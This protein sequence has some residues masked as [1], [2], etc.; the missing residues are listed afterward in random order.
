MTDFVSFKKQFKGDLV[1]PSDPG[2][3]EAIDRWAHNAARRAKVVA[4]VKDPQDVSLAIKYAKANALPIAIRGGGHSAAGT[5]SSEDGLVID[6]S[7]YINGVTVDAEKRLAYIGG[8]AVWKTVDHAA[9]QH[10]LATVGGTVNH[11]GVGGLILGGGYGWLSAQHGLAIDN[12]VQATIVPADGSVLTANSS[13]NSDLFWAIRGG[14]C[15]FGVVT[16]FVLKLFPQRRS[17]FAGQIVFTP[18]KLEQVGAALDKWW[19][20]AGSSGKAS[21]MSVMTR[22]PDG[23][24]CI[25]VSLFYNG[26]EAEGR[27]HYKILYDI[28]A[29]L[30]KEV[31]YEEVNGMQNAL[32]APGLNYYMKGALLSDTPSKDLRREVFD[33]V[34]SLS[35]EDLNV[36]II[37]ELLPHDK[38]NSVPAD[39]TPYRRNLHGNTLI[40]IQWKEHTPEKGKAARAAAHELAG[41]MP[42][43]EGY[44]N[45]AGTDDAASS[46]TGVAP[47]EK[48]QELFGQH[49]PRLQAI[50]KKYDP[51]M[52]FHKW[53]LIV[54]A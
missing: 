37:L 51:E 48:S 30:A 42:K 45:Y 28:V 24:P 14:G 27:E 50:K 23:N 53:F 20:N 46:K 25:V 12:L 32:A 15:N 9:I 11:T 10:G 33:R 36:A 35:K 34:I 1:T 22:G 21:L 16:E 17:V 5:S 43:G 6:L 8:G 7:K 2:Y 26:S 29:D 40:L 18:D 47:A 54:P 44:G 19:P 52:I 49:Y 31:P 39:V 4:F 13:E 38:I 3:E 41:L